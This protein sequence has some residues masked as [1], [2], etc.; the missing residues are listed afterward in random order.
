MSAS[1]TATVDSR[2]AQSNREN[3]RKSTGPRTPEGKSRA[4]QNAVTHGAFAQNL[5]LPHEDKEHFAQHYCSMLK[6]LHPANAIQ[7]FLAQRIIALTW[8]LNRLHA[9]ESFLHF[10]RIAQ[11]QT[12]ADKVKKSELSQKLAPDYA[13]LLDSDN[14]PDGLIL[15]YEYDTPKNSAFER[16]SN[17]EQRLSNMLHRAIRDLK[18]LQ[19][20]AEDENRSS[21]SD[22]N[23][24]AEFLLPDNEEDDDD[25]EEDDKDEQDPQDTP[26]RSSAQAGA[27]GH[28]VTAEPANSICENEPKCQ[29][30]SP[31]ES[32]GDLP[33]DAGR[34]ALGEGFDL[35]E[36]GHGGV[37]GKGG[38]QCP[39]RPT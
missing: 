39:M 36:L 11:F 18:S 24:L 9:A 25:E 30:V 28:P 35:L 16:L 20:Q 26:G 13:S 19:Q 34:T 31:P 1:A 14:I 21:D 2:R 23:P 6:S 27:D 12:N 7:T 4:A 8:R 17:A 32:P 29:S 10:T 5:L 33:L 37:A 3:A 15:S 22:E 38:E